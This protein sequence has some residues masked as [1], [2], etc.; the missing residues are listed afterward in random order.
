MQNDIRCQFSKSGNSNP[1]YKVVDQ[2]FKDNPSSS[3][4]NNKNPEA[5]TIH[6]TSID[7]HSTL[8]SSF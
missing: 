2:N 1:S 4:S 6:S 5:E 3:S 7:K 8:I